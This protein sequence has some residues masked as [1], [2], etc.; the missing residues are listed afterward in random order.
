MPSIN[1][2]SP[3]SIID[4]LRDPFDRERSR[5]EQEFIDKKLKEDALEAWK[6]SRR[7]LTPQAEFLER[8]AREKREAKMAE[9]TNGLLEL[10]RQERLRTLVRTTLEATAS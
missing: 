9:V 7:L 8:K 10:I 5:H 4:E 2:P 3:T 1:P 6:K